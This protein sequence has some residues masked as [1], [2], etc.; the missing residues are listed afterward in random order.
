M[1]A[2]PAQ[3]KVTGQLEI[4]YLD[5]GQADCIYIL[6]PNGETLLIDA[7]DTPTSGSVVQSIK[8]NN[9]NGVI[10]YIVT[11]HPHADHIGGMAAVINA[12]KVKNIWMPEK[13]HTTKTFENLLDAIDSKGLTIQTAKA[14]K[15]L[16]DY[17][18]LKAVFVAPNGIGYGKENNYSA[19]VLLTYNDRRF[20]FMGDAEQESEAEILAAGIDISADVLKAGHHGS[21]T[22]STKAFIQKVVPKYAVISSGKG[23]SYGHPASQTLAT[24]A[25]FGIEIKRTD[26]SGTIIFF[27][28]GEKISFTTYQTEV[29]PRAPTTAPTKTT[30]PETAK[31]APAKTQEQ[32]VTVYATRTGK[33]YHADG[34]R[35]LSQ[36]KIPMD[37]SEARRKYDPCSV[38]KPPQ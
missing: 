19:A 31:E 21:H 26:E 28:D 1:P 25:E 22:S 34:C 23:N 15:V 20:L 36:S 3:R 16:F 27:C 17:G 4:A 14:G 2:D 10:D 8:D 13:I 9:A 32:S 6:L 30:A 7:G 5:V 29:Q 33:K 38:C 11:T 18:N 37:L 35:Y 12:F 24:L